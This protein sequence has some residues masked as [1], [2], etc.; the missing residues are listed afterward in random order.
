MF[1]KQISI[2]IENQK[3]RLSYITDVLEKNNINI[4]ALFLAET[5]EFGI[6]RIIVNEPE[7]CEEILKKNNIV[8][9]ITPVIGFEVDDTPGGIGKV[10][11]LL[12]EKNINVEYIY[13]FVEKIQNKA[14]VAAKTGDQEQA[15]TILKSNGVQVLDPKTLK[16]I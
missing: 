1:I 4:R 9:K 13:A 12:A 2:F 11:R 10:L 7:I 6:L 16:N 5:G 8:A 3:G 14:I 15:Y